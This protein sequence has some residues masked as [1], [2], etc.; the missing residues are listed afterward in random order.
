MRRAA[1]EA[2]LVAEFGAE[3]IA[4]TR[5]LL[6]AILTRFDADDAIRNRRVR[7]PS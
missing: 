7:P 1:L 3:R 5:A 4:D 6:A 2:E